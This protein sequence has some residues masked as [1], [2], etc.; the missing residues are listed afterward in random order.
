MI[1][2]D[3]EATEIALSSKEQLLAKLQNEKE[4]AEITGAIIG[5]SGST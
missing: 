3:Q 1:L 4:S 5:P 2:T